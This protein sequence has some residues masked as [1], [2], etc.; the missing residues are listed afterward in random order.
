MVFAILNRKRENRRLYNLV[1]FFRGSEEDAVWIHQNDLGHC[2]ELVKAYNEK[3]T[4]V[5]YSE[6]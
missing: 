1:Q 3:K 2:Q 6:V 4:K 5:I